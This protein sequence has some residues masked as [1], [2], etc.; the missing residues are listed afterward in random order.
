MPPMFRVCMLLMTWEWNN[1]VNQTLRSAVPMLG[2]H[3]LQSSRPHPGND[4]KKYVGQLLEMR[5]LST[6]FVSI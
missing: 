2:F 5:V 3:K 4:K 6:S 1:Q